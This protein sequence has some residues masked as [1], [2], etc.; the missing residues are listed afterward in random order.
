M[1]RS[2]RFG[3]VPNRQ[4]SSLNT[5]AALPVSTINGVLSNRS[6]RLYLGKLSKRYIQTKHFPV[7][8]LFSMQTFGTPWPSG[9]SK[10][11]NLSAER[12]R[13]GPI[14]VNALVVVQSA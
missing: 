5:L 13:A 10:R 4:V 12:R 6:N 2:W 9:L 11:C 7:A 8:K 14:P 3:H 1:S